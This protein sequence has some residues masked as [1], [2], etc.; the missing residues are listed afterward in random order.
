MVAAGRWRRRHQ[1]SSSDLTHCD[2]PPTGSLPKMVVN[3]FTKKVAPAGITVLSDACINYN[4]WKKKQA[5]PD[6]KPW[7]RPETNKLKEV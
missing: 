3:F 4:D 2:S 1:P 5:E 7:L 6:Y